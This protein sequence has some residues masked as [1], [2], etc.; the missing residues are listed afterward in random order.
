MVSVLTLAISYLVM[1]NKND[2]KLNVI[3]EEARWIYEIEIDNDLLIKQEFIPALDGK[4]GFK[5]KSDAEKIGRLVI[6]R[7]KRKK[8]PTITYNDLLKHDIKI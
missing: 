6:D 4:Q 2:Y 5:S 7:L 1:P 8:S 3:K